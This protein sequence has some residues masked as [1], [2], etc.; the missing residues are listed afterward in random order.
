MDS[1]E[2]VKKKE[3]LRMLVQRSVLFR[4]VPENLKK[5]ENELNILEQSASSEKIISYLITLFRELEQQTTTTV[6]A[7]KQ[8]ISGS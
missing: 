5:F 7:L 3:E 8:I 4:A 6:S 2:F 1:S